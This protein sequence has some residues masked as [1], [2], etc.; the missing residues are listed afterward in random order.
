MRWLAISLFV[1][2][3]AACT[4]APQSEDAPDV[5]GA[6]GAC[7]PADEVKRLLAETRPSEDEFNALMSHFSICR[8]E[9]NVARQ[10]A[11]RLS[12]A[13]LPVAMHYIA[14]TNLN[15]QQQLDT[16]APTLE[17]ASR[18]G[19]ASAQEDLRNLV[20]STAVADTLGI[21]RVRPPIPVK[22]P[23][24][25]RNPSARTFVDI[26]RSGNLDDEAFCNE[27]VSQ[28][29]VESRAC[30]AN[31]FPAAVLKRRIRHAQPTQQTLPNFLQETA[32]RCDDGE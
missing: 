15:T 8:Q 1:C 26:C 17:R 6:D 3:A 9:L 22:V 32:A 18:L 21:E 19:S 11:D 5:A 30:T 4:P 2:T 31:H 14:I 27:A 24:R 16:V 23:A 7:L 20:A 10:I 12:E 28:F 13:E 25:Y 29:L